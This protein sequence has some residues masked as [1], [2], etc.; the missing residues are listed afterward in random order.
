MSVPELKRTQ[1]IESAREQLKSA[2]M[3][4]AYGKLKES[5]KSLVFASKQ[6]NEVGLLDKS[7]EAKYESSVTASTLGMLD[8]GGN[9]PFNSS[10]E[11]LLFRQYEMGRHGGKNIELNIIEDGPE[12]ADFE[13][14]SRLAEMYNYEYLKHRDLPKGITNL[15]D[16][17][18]LAMSIGSM[19]D[20]DNP[21]D[22]LEH[23]NLYE[24]FDKGRDEQTNWK[25]QVEKFQQLIESQGIDKNRTLSVYESLSKSQGTFNETVHEWRTDRANNEPKEEAKSLKKMN[26]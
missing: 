9:N 18:M 23:S 8:N 5:N 20:L 13:T 24:F 12:R 1:L 21:F 11:G 22:K 17:N 2:L 6:A 14:F 3:H 19:S 25:T 10:E 4:E 26:I 7:L 16:A 15:R